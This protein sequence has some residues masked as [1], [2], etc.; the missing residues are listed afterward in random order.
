MYTYK[1]FKALMPNKSTQATTPTHPKASAQG[2]VKRHA[3]GSPYTWPCIMKH[4]MLTSGC[5]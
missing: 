3:L 5:V 1:L 2:R 4:K